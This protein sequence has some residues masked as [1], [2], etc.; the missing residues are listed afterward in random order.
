MLEKVADE[1]LT[2]RAG[3]EGSECMWKRGPK[4]Q[5]WIPAWHMGWGV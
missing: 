5:L 4:G 3:V 2:C 1:K